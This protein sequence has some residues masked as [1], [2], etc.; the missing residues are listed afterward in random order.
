MNLIQIR[1]KF[2]QLSGRYDLV[3]DDNSDHGANFFINEAS[4][5][6]DRTVETQKS[7]ASYMRIVPID[8]WYC[9]FPTARA[10]KE[11]WISTVDGKW[12]LEKKRIQDLVSEYLCS[13]PGSWVSGTPTYYSPAITR[14]IPENLTPAALAT[15]ATYINT[16]PV[17]SQEYNAVI[18]S[19]KVDK[20]ALIEVIGLFYSMEMTDD[21]DENYWSSVHPML[22]I[23]AAIRQ[24]YVVAANSPMLKVVEANINEDLTRIGMDTVEQI[25]AEIDEMEG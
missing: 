22:L 12:Q 7:W 23:Q 5:W 4:R 8:S 6:L 17:L 16:L 21:N 18:F 24:T 9:R 11:V 3:N 20:E 25:I 15:F 1:E 13:P 10:I 2:K 14:Y 19:S